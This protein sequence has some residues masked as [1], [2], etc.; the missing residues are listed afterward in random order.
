[1][2]V[3]NIIAILILAVFCFPQIAAA[4]VHWF[5]FYLL[6]YNQRPQSAPR[7]FK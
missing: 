4:W 1:M 2:I 7:F 5:Q 3:I 6:K